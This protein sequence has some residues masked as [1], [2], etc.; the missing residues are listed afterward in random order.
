MGSCFKDHS[1]AFFTS[2][3]TLVSFTQSPFQA[4]PRIGKEQG[5]QLIA[6]ATFS[7]KNYAPV[8]GFPQVKIGNIFDK[9]RATISNSTSIVQ[10]FPQLLGVRR[11]VQRRFASN[12]IKS[13][14]APLAPTKII[15]SARRSCDLDF[16]NGL[17]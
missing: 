8:Y 17:G 9:I 1:K 7:K 13:P 11:S 5:H 2:F 15:A 12:Q 16:D 4:L 6:S 10:N 14:K 3:A